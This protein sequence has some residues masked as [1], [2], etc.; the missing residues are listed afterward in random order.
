MINLFCLLIFFFCFV[1]I[2]WFGPQSISVKSF[3]AQCQWQCPVVYP[4]L[5]VVIIAVIIGVTIHELGHL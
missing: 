5:I 2:F 3:L 1:L 4:S